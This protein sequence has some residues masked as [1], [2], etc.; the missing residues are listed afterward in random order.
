M[1]SMSK[2]FKIYAT[3]VVIISTPAL[4]ICGCTLVFYPFSR[5]LQVDRTAEPDMPIDW[6]FKGIVWPLALPYEAYSRL[7]KKKELI[8]FS[9]IIHN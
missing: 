5:M 3:G 4:V 2:I 9:R 8:I 6:V 7:C 1:G